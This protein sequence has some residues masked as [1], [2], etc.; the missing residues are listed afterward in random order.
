MITAT[1]YRT[2]RLER[3][4]RSE[5]WT[6][7][8]SNLKFMLWNE[9]L[10]FIDEWIL[11]KNLDTPLEPTFFCEKCGH[12]EIPKPYGEHGKLLSRKRRCFTCDFWIEVLSD[13]NTLIIDGKS[14]Q[15]GPEFSN[16]GSRGFGGQAFTIRILKSGNIIRT[17]N[18]WHQGEIP[19]LFYRPNTAE[20]V[21]E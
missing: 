12:R 1:H 18:L 13:P 19:R 8:V 7:D 10:A 21:N 17:T 16:S 14:Y 11:Y 15:M 2:H 6:T 4:D 5:L 3:V 9:A 20:F